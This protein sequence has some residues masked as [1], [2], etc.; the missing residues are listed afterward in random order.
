MLQNN[1]QSGAELTVM[2]GINERFVGKKTCV[3][4]CILGQKSEQC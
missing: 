4:I 3:A 2:G 1:Y